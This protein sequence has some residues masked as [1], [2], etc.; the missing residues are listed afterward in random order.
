[1]GSSCFGADNRHILNHSLYLELLE[2][3]QDDAF[4]LLRFLD[5]DDTSF[6]LESD[7]CV[8]VFEHLHLEAYRVQQF[9]G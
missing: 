6:L 7:R 8:Y 9:R 1:M 4:I 5:L 3:F 2:L